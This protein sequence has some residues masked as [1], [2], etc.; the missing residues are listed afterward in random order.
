[1]TGVDWEH[2]R[3]K[4]RW[5]NMPYTYLYRAFNYEEELLYVG[6]ADKLGNRFRRHENDSRWWWECVDGGR[7]EIELLAASRR[8]CELI[9][10]SVIREERPIHNVTHNTDNPNRFVS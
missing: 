3:E 6:I 9:E 5:T 7:F 1:M 8:S 4:H 10:M 2:Q